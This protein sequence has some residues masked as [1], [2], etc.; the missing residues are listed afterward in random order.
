MFSEVK[1]CNIY[2]TIVFIYHIHSAYIDLNDIIRIRPSRH[3]LSSR[4]A[5]GIVQAHVRKKKNIIPV[6]KDTLIQWS[7]VY[8]LTQHIFNK[9]SSLM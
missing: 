2:H 6:L 7:T 9:K 5:L 3:A 8:E 1:I 4:M